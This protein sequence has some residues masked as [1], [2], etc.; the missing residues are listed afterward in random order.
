MDIGRVFNTIGTK[1]RLSSWTDA[2]DTRIFKAVM[3]QEPSELLVPQSRLEFRHTPS[4][5]RS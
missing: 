5:Q 3:L 2:G 4:P 1:Q